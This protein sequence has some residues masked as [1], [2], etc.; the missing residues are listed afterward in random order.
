MEVP[1]GRLRP[2]GPKAAFRVKIRPRTHLFVAQKACIGILGE[3]VPVRR[4]RAAQVHPVRGAEVLQPGLPES[5]LAYA[6]LRLQGARGRRLT[7][8]P[9]SVCGV[10]RA[11]DS[12][13]YR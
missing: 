9:K 1:Q 12:C 8:R 5:L 2:H 10:L 4:P 6:L 3:P 11:L 13:Y 7:W